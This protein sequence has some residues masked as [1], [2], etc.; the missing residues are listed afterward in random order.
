MGNK[1]RT[2]VAISL[3][4]FV[5][6]AMGKTQGAL[7][8]FKLDVRWVRLEGIHLTLKFLGDIDEKDVAKVG[9]AMAAGVRRIA[10]TDY[11]LAVSGIAGPTG[12]T[13]E[14]PVGT[15]L[16]ALADKDGTTCWKDAFQGDR[17]QIKVQ[18]S[19]AAL[20]RILEMVRRKTG[21]GKRER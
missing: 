2:F 4:D 19:D 12:G 3:P 9:E 18:T 7:R 10:G 1:I 20:K 17:L 11:G 6:R 21:G 15:V 14:K 13:P 5:L 8:R 16:M